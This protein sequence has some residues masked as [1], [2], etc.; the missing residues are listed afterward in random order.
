MASTVV[1]KSTVR[2]GIVGSDINYDLHSLFTASC[3]GLGLCVKEC[4]ILW[5]TSFLVSD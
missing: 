3:F 4:C 5:V 2:Q 1:T